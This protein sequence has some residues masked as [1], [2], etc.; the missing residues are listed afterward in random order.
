M[1]ESLLL[2]QTSLL[3]KGD[4]TFRTSS[5][6][7]TTITTSG[8]GTGFTTEYSIDG[9]EL[10]KAGTTFSIPAGEH[11]VTL[12]LDVMTGTVLDM[13]PFKDILTE[14]TDWEDFQLL[15]IQFYNCTK[16]TKVPDYLSPV[17]TD[18]SSMFEGCTS[19]NQD[20][21][22]WDVSKVTVISY[23]FQN[24]TSFNQDLSSMVFKSSVKR[25]YYDRGATA[26]NTAYRPKF[27]G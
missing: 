13:L 17:I 2:V 26:W 4:I 10:V 1:L 19:F 3:V 22:A 20:I 12:K 9:A 6:S 8:L 5:A 11:E 15:N 24:C 14:V 18:M 23:M 21:S 16:L 27:T 7:A 25:N